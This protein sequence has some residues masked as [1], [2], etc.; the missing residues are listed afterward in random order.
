MIYEMDVTSR[1]LRNLKDHYYLMEK[2][3]KQE[4]HSLFKREI[5]AYQNQIKELQENFLHYQDRMKSNYLH[6]VTENIEKL[7]KQ[8][9]DRSFLC[10]YSR[11]RE[12][13]DEEEEEKHDSRRVIE[14]LE[15]KSKAYR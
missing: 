15:G 9:E 12:I 2:F 8:K 5:S 13:D 10:D 6:Q 3:T 4:V 14:S 11:I 1:E 7:Q